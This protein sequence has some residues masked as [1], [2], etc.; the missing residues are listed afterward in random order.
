VFVEETRNLK[1]KKEGKTSDPIVEVQC[2]GDTKFFGP[3]KKVG[4]GTTFWGEHF[5]F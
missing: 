2:F 4:N 1:P 3:K 5:F